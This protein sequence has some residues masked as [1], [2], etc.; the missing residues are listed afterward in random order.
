MPSLY[1]INERLA[2]LEERFD[3]FKVLM[4]ERAKAGDDRAA[5]T[6]W[7]IVGLAVIVL[8]LVAWAAGNGFDIGTIANAVS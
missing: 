2:R 5:R 4:E 8:G 1:E 3:A 7:Q 6:R